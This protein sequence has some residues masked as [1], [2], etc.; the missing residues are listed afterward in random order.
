MPWERLKKW[1]K[2]EKIK[3]TVKLNQ[4]IAI[5][6]VQ[7]KKKKKKKKKNSSGAL[8]SREVIVSNNRFHFFTS[9]LSEATGGRLENP[10]HLGAS[11]P[12]ILK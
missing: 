2:D 1:Q 6:V 3:N 8:Q 9:N 4:N 10:E 11:V 5:P 7:K 12:Q